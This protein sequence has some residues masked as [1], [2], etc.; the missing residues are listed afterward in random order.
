M[1]I[2]YAT[3]GGT[4]SRAADL[5]TRER[6]NAIADRC[7]SNWEIASQLFGDSSLRG[8]RPDVG[9]QWT[10]VIRA[11]CTGENA[12]EI[13]TQGYEIDVGDFMPQVKVPTLVIHR[14]GD[15]IVPFASGQK[16][17]ASIPSARFVP[18]EGTMHDPTLGDTDAVVAAIDEF[19]GESEEKPKPLAPE[20]LFTDVEGSTALTQRLGERCGAWGH[21][22]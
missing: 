19:L 6:I 17:A 4:F 21:W 20:D 9:A 3:I 11:A 10:K 5:A 16:L 2:A 12:A 18:L 7:R 15:A 14:R 8:Q 22:V 13:Y 1:S